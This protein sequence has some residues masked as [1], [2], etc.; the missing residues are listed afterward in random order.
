MK[1]M[2]RIGYKDSSKER[3][4]RGVLQ[5]TRVRWEPK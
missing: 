4:M 1:L 2:Y 5:M 3:V